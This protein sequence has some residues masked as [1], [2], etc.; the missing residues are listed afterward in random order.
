MPPP[1]L[2]LPTVEIVLLLLQGDTDMDVVA[3]GH[4][5]QCGQLGPAGQVMGGAGVGI[6]SF[7]GLT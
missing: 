7:S 1:L 6:D 2:R 5:D 3:G 4:P